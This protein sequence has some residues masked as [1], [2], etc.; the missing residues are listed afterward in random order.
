MSTKEATIR[1]QVIGKRL[2]KVSQ[3]KQTTMYQLDHWLHL[4]ERK[5]GW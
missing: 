4:K 3:Q 5:T 2:G 1:T